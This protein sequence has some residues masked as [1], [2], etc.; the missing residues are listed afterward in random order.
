MRWALERRHFAH[1]AGGSHRRRGGAARVA[2]V[3][4][5]ATDPGN[6]TAADHA[7]TGGCVVFRH[8]PAGPIRLLDDGRTVARFAEAPT[9]WAGFAVALV[10]G[11]GPDLRHIEH[12]L[13]D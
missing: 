9:R 3:C 4:L 6:P 13:Q 8:S 2:P 1:P 12:A 7:A 11:L 10:C 5:V